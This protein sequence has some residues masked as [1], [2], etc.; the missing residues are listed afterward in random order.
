[1]SAFFRSI[2]H[3]RS[4]SLFIK[5]LS[6]FLLMCLLLTGLFS[7]FSA[8]I[9]YSELEEQL[10][11]S[12]IN[13]MSLTDTT[14]DVLMG[15]VE[16]SIRAASQNAT[17]ISAVIAPDLSR[18]QR[19]YELVHYLNTTAENSTIVSRILLYV[20]YD[21]TVFTS[22]GAA[23]TLDACLD[24][25]IIQRHLEQ[26][27]KPMDWRNPG[28]NVSLHIYDGKL[29]CCLDF[30]LEGSYCNGTLFFEINQ[31]VFYNELNIQTEFDVYIFNEK[32]QPLF[33]YPQDSFISVLTQKDFETMRQ[34]GSG[35]LP[36]S[37]FGDQTIGYYY[38]APGGWL[39]V[40]PVPLRILSSVLGGLIKIILPMFLLS[41]LLSAALSSYLSHAIYQPIRHL[42]ELVSKG[43]RKWIPSKQ[44]LSELEF[45]GVAYQD[46]VK[47]NDLLTGIVTR[48]TDA[49][50]EKM[51]RAIML[52]R[53]YEP[54]DV[55]EN[56]QVLNT[57]FTELGGYLVIALYITQKDGTQLTMLQTDLYK[58]SITNLMA[59]IV[60]D[61]CIYMAAT[62]DAGHIAMAICFD[63]QTSADL[64]TQT[65]SAALSAIRQESEHLPCS[66][67]SGAGKTY[68]SIYDLKYSY[69]EAIEKIHYQ[70]YMRAAV[71]VQED[72]NADASRTDYAERARQLA[73][74]LCGVQ[75]DSAMLCSRVLD[76]FFSARPDMDTLR[77]RMTT[78]ADALY[79]YTGGDQLDGAGDLEPKA[80]ALR[81]MRQMTSPHQL[82]EWADGLCTSAADFFSVCNSRKKYR[83]VLRAKEYIE[84]HVSEPTLSLN[85]VAA[86]LNITPTYL[87][88]L[89]KEYQ[90]RNFIEYVN[91][92][93]IRRAMMYLSTTD[94]SISEIGFKCGFSSAQNFTRVFKKYKQVPPGQYRSSVTRS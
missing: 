78:L 66:I 27:K 67:L 49:L 50:M 20:S 23:T 30:P 92:L 86:S 13:L 55:Q 37:T 34:D 61:E 8:T 65:V 7:V 21:K 54:K 45:L 89:F 83:Y 76:E 72:Y 10:Y 87:S 5:I 82:R 33:N 77:K 6:F 88:R 26:Q 58:A 71:P 12:N 85:D 14:A 16:A 35:T 79:E 68:R 51:L 2:T 39:Y 69:R 74:D 28:G 3:P 15:N 80:E 42:T 59:S 32:D 22:D 70:S 75:P 60:K 4:Q 24:A 73:E 43:Q 81:R 64:I 62:I 18:T 29:Y 57:P 38:S 63:E 91:E 40:Y 84:E 52:G 25:G 41:L 94:L 46:A 19:N 53:E 11:H 90:Q 93:R 47:S 44:T 56:L 36:R 17:I 48:S 31:K 9:L 1:M